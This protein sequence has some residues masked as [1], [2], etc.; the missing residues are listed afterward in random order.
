MICCT[1]GREE[2]VEMMF[3]EKEIRLKLF[4]LATVNMMKKKKK[5]ILVYSHS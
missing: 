1:G 5:Q 4:T 3:F 2:F